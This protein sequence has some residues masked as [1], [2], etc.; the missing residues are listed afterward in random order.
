MLFFEG[1]SL[2][3]LFLHLVEAGPKKFK[4]LPSGPPSEPPKRSRTIEI[5]DSD[6]EAAPSAPSSGDVYTPGRIVAPGPSNRQTRRNGVTSSSAGSA[7]TPSQPPANGTVSLPL[8]ATNPIPP[9]NQAAPRALSRAST[10]ERLGRLHLALDEDPRNT[11]L[12]T[13]ATSPPPVPE[14]DIAD[15]AMGRTLHPHFIFNQA[16]RATRFDDIVQIINI[17]LHRLEFETNAD[18]IFLVDRPDV[19][20]SAPKS[21]TVRGLPSRSIL[22]NQDLASIAARLLNEFRTTIARVRRTERAALLQRGRAELAATRASSSHGSSLAHGITNAGRPPPL[23]QHQ[24]K[25]RKRSPSNTE[26]H[27]VIKRE[28]THSPL[29]PSAQGIHDLTT[30]DDGDDE[31]D[32]APG[33]MHLSSKAKGKAR[34]EPE[35]EPEPEEGVE[36]AADGAGNDPRPLPVV[37]QHAGLGL[38]VHNRAPSRA[39]SSRPRVPSKEHAG[40]RRGHSRTP[41]ASGSQHAEHEVLADDLAL[42]TRLSMQ[43]LRRE[44]ARRL[45][46]ERQASTSGASHTLD[47]ATPRAHRVRREVVLDL[48]SEV[49]DLLEDMGIPRERWIGVEQVWRSYPSR[50]YSRELGEF[51]LDYEE[52]LE[53]Q[54]VQY[55]ALL[56]TRY[57]PPG[58]Q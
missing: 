2:L 36:V 22:A 7:T 45:R 33:A 54:A 20:S 13:R 44:E 50:D 35:P 12:Y 9:L 55:L 25:K 57:P 32:V 4:R 56:L 8:P 42:A 38:V 5:N 47:D 46:E 49:T 10:P 58:P 1:L 34:A 16:A 29:L 19:D 48:P 21:E 14:Y 24:S 41:S 39:G 15:R 28:R 30:A 52:D 26:P 27:P 51:F 17:L 3:L 23:P 18:Y 11:D 43:T 37:R 31:G 6:D 40:N 53:D